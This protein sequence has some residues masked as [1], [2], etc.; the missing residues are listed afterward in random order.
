MFPHSMLHNPLFFL[1]QSVF[2]S[3]YPNHIEKEKK[4]GEMCI[5]PY[6]YDIVLSTES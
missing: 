4:G 5:L 2:Y 6:C 1:R 3:F